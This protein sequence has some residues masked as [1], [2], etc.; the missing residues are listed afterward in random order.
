MNVFVSCYVQNDFSKTGS[1]R[2]HRGMRTLLP[3]IWDPEA[4]DRGS[5]MKL[6]L[7]TLGK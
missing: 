7:I 4:L 6:G 3:P 5:S 1:V 2:T